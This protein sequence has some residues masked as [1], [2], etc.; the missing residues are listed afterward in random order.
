[1]SHF[2]D[3]RAPYLIFGLALLLRLAYIL[4]IDASPLFAFPVVDARTYAEQAQRLAAGHWLGRGEGPYWQPPLYPYFLALIKLLAGQS[5]FYAARLLQI[6]LGAGTCL[7]TYHLGR[8][9]FTRPIGLAAGLSAALY[10]PL[11]FFDGE[12]LPATLGT[13]LAL[14]GLYLLQDALEKGAG[15]RLAIAGLVFGLAALALPTILPF[16]GTTI[17]FALWTLYRQKASWSRALKRTALLLFGLLLAVAPV[18]LRNYAIGHDSVLISYNAGVNFYIGNNPDYPRTLQVRPGWE[19]DDIVHMPDRAGIGPPSLKSRYFFARSWDYIAAQPLDYLVLLVRKTGALWHG[20]ES[21]RNQAIY[22]WRNYSSILAATL[23]K[24]GLAFPFGLVAP[25]ALLGLLLAL[26]RQG[27]S[28][29]VLFVAS[30]SLTIIAFFPTARYRLPLLPLLLLFAALA[31]QW[32]YRQW[33]QGQGRSAALGLAV[34]ALFALAANYRLAPMDM[35]GDAAIHYNLG[36][37]YAKARQLEA[38]HRA[39]SRA[40]SIDSTYWQAWLNL[41]SMEGTSGNLQGAIDIFARLGQAQPHRVNVWINLAHAHIRAQ[42][43][44]GALRAYQQALK[45]DPRRREIYIELIALYTRAG[46]FAKAEDVLVQAQRYR[47]HDR[48]LFQR[49]YQDARRRRLQGP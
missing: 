15:W 7:M 25:L 38:A 40:V 37:A 28:L 47:P 17:L 33:S 30:Y 29:P 11:L 31:V 22:Y 35:Q 5:F 9:L 19:W 12:L 8:R 10:G 20:D 44:G 34:V 18:T 46:A 4:Q 6:L 14:T 1:M 48:E 13:F 42:Q 2:I 43:P 45:A 16:A 26:R 32:I 21:G 27:L 24:W 36:N 41:G 39:F 23:W 49:F 3:Q